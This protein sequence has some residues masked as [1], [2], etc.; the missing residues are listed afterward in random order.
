MYDLVF[1]DAPCSG[2]GTLRRHPEIRWRINEK[3]I[4]LLC[5]IQ[6]TM[7]DQAAKRVKNHGI[8]AYS[9]CTVVLEEN[10]KQ[11]KTFLKEHDSYSLLYDK[12]YMLK[13]NQ[14]DAH[15]L[16]LLSKN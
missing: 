5:Q 3:D 14:S 16:S 1:I 15:F 9:T 6:K 7:L 10:K 13:L 8:L 4:E 12:K 11:I 2:L